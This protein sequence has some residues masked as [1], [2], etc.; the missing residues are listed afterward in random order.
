MAN[1]I[2]LLGY[3]EVKKS[4]LCESVFTEID[5]PRITQQIENV[6]VSTLDPNHVLPNMGLVTERVIGFNFANVRRRS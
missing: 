1:Q 4:T 6:D 3:L 5:L 2:A